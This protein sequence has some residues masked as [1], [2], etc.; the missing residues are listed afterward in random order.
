MA[1][2]DKVFTHWARYM[3]RKIK[4]L[5]DLYLGRTDEITT[6]LSQRCHGDILNMV[7]VIWLIIETYAE[8]QMFGLHK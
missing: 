4:I 7:S 5:D 3:H 1:F 8:P 6:Q 2:N